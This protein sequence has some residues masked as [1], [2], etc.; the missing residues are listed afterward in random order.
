[1]SKF[2]YKK[3]RSKHSGIIKIILI[4]IIVGGLWIFFSDSILPRFTNDIDILTYLATA[5]GMLFIIVTAAMLY[6]LIKNYVSEIKQ[7]KENLHESEKRYEELA[8]S[9]PQMIFEI[10]QD[11]IVKFTNI[12]SYKMFG[13]SREEITSGFSVFSAIVPEDRKRALSNMIQIMKGEKH[14]I[15]EYTAL[16]KDGT[17]FPVVIFSNPIIT[18][19]LT[20]GVRGIAIDITERKIME[21]QLIRTKEKAEESDKLKSEFLAQMSHEIRTPLNVILSY[22]SFLRDELK[23]Y[24]DEDQITGFN[25]V[26]TA[27]RRLIRTIDLILNMAEIHAGKLDVRTS[28]I[29]LYNILTELIKEFELSAKEKNLELSCSNS[30]GV[31]PILKSDGYIVTEVFQNLID[32]AIKYTPGGHIGITI[33]KNE[34]ENYCVAVKD[35]GIGIAS[36]YIDKIF[37]PF[38]QEDTGYSRRFDGN[39]LGLALVKKYLELINAEIKVE[40][41]KGKGSIFTVSFN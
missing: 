9:L 10:D 13:Y 2:N 26:D 37:L 25:S 8:N 31:M 5:K 33:Y 27:G 6:F 34:G 18:G 7:T 30:C 4:Y 14:D 17:T 40:S 19:N 3:D 38:S 22:N 39:G 1:M 28:D 29:N 21:E 11:G 32:N 35:T 24:L 23:N 41:V 15:E 20:T 36:E 16:R 12:A